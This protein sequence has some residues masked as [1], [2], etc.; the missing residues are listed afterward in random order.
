MIAKRFGWP[1]S[2]PVLRKVN[3][4]CTTND[5]GIVARKAIALARNGIGIFSQS[6]SRTTSAL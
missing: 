4:F 1:G 2:R 5:S 3:R 6:T